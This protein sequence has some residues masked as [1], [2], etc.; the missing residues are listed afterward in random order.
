MIAT[1]GISSKAGQSPEDPLDLKFKYQYNGLLAAVLSGAGSRST[2][3]MTD[4]IRQLT[5]EEATAGA[6]SIARD[7]LALHP[8]AVQALVSNP[9][10]GM[11]EKAQLKALAMNGTEGLVEKLMGFQDPA[12]RQEL[13]GNLASAEKLGAEISRS[14]VAQASL[15]QALAGTEEALRPSLTLSFAQKAAADAPAFAKML[16]AQLE[17]VKQQE[18]ATIFLLNLAP[19]AAGTALDIWESSPAE[20]QTTSLRGLVAGLAPKDP[21]KAIALAMQQ[22]NPEVRN[23]ALAVAFA[24]W[25][26]KAPQA[27][28]AELERLAPQLDLVAMKRFLPEAGNFHSGPGSTLLNAYFMNDSTVRD[29]LNALTPQTTP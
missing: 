21:Q 22:K 8:E 28:A 27:A 5:P 15:L 14:K 10:P 7:Y 16:W 17:P 25:G 20:V 9:N 6:D 12:F 19:E 18:G 4:F 1:F 26:E 23:D 29:R 11:A 13:L 3:E 2:A 24:H